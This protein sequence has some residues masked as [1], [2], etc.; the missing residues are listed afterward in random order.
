MQL[1]FSNISI[2]HIYLKEC[3]YD[4]LRAKSDLIIE[5]NSDLRKRIYSR[6]YFFRN[7]H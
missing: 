7:W 4:K 6:H 1:H 5:D 3:M 2:I